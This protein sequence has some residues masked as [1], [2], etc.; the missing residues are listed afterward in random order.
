MSNLVDNALC[1]NHPGGQI[2]IST[3]SPPG[4]VAITVSNTGLTVSADQV[5]RLIQPFGQTGSPRVHHSNG[6]RLGLA[7]VAAIARAHHTM[8]FATPRPQGGLEVVVTFESYQR[9][10]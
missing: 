2:A 9:P 1:H 8:S 10:A 7:I 3:I 6:H 5:D 4:R